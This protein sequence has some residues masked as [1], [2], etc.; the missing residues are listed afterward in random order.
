MPEARGFGSTPSRF[1]TTP[2]F[3]SG[4]IDLT[5]GGRGVKPYQPS[6][7]WEPVAFTGSKHA[8]VCARQ[9]ERALTVGASTRSS[10]EPRPPPFMANFDA[11]SRE[12]LLHPPRAEQHSAPGPS[13]S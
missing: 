4:L 5:M 8:V 10:S 6:N 3:V 9:G 11:P 7:I 1:A 2:L 13:S 12:F